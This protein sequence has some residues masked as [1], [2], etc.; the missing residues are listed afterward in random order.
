MLRTASVVVVVFLLNKTYVLKDNHKISQTIISNSHT[1]MSTLENDD[2]KW[3]LVGTF[4]TTTVD[5]KH[6]YI[7]KSK[8]DL[9]N[10]VSCLLLL[11]NNV[12]FCLGSCFTSSSE[13]SQES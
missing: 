5:I 13:F 8:V 11:L 2:N 6:Y 9:N 7:V 10:Y 12:Y 3:H 4:K 1:K